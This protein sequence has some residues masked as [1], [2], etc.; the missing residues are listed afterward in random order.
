MGAPKRKIGPAQ[1]PQPVKPTGATAT[2]IC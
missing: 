1:S 2:M